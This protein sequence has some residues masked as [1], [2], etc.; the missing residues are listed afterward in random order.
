MEGSQIAYFTMEIGLKASIP[1]YSGGLGVLAGDTIK[2]AADLNVPMVCM[3]MMYHQGY[4]TQGFDGHWQTAEPTIWNPR[5]ELKLLPNKVRVEI[6]GR[7]IQV[8][9]W[10]YVVEGIQGH[11]VPVYFLDTDIEGNSEWDRSLTSRLYGGDHWFRMCQEIVLGIGGV[12]MLRELNIQVDKY[13]MNEGHAAFLTLELRKDAEE[14]DHEVDAEEYQLI[15]KECV[16]TTHTPV[17]AGHDAFEAEWVQRALGN[18]CDLASLNSYED[19]RL[20]MTLLAMNHSAFINGVAKKHGQVAR[21][22]FP[23]YQI[24]AITNGVH[25]QTWT[26]PHIRRLFDD[27]IAGWREDNYM[28]R[29]SLNIPDKEVWHA[30]EAAK[31]DLVRMLADKTGK[32]WI[33]GC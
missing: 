20:N 5:E 15:R 28:L 14:D 3:T 30:H 27:Y 19:G 23:G 8:Q 17:P 2:S 33:R 26:S 29:Y 11:E 7:T 18:Q 21:E 4:F 24:N 25:A 13:H 1:T 16:F 10:K 31:E 12:K 22:M 32:R 9:A 6:E